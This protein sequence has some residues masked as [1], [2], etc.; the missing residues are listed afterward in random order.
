MLCVILIQVFD[1]FPMSKEKII[2]SLYKVMCTGTSPQSDNKVSNNDYF[3]RRVLGFRAEME[4][5]QTIKE[6]SGYRFLEGGMFF[7]P[8]LDGSREMKNSFLY[9]TFDSLPPEDYRQIYDKISRWDEIKRMIYVK[10]NLDDWGEEKFL[11][12]TGNKREDT[13]ILVPD[14]EFYDFDSQSGFIKTNADDFSSILS[15]GRERKNNAP[16]FKLR[17]RE[18][19]DYFGQYELDTLK[20]IYANRYFVDNK[21]RDVVMHMIDFD[22]F[23]IDE[24]NTFIVEIKEKSPIKDT[25]HPDNRDKWAYGWDTRRLLWYKYIQQKIGLNVLYNIRQIDNRYDRNFVKWDSI[26]LSDFLKAVSWSSVR[27]GGGGED[28]LTVPYEHFSDLKET[29]VRDV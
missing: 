16:K 26:F 4:F 15:I 7:S 6:N 17:K 24:S 2:D 14:Y 3:K 13:D 18:Q 1:D 28:T 12:N 11:V 20:K 9:V 19:F 27:G 25:K 10:I 8:K 21:K 29:I 23:I 5:E 22:G